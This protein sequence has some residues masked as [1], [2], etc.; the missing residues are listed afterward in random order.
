MSSTYSSSLRIELIGS[1]DQA[2]AWGATT[3]SNLA[4]IMDTAIAGYQA[5]TVTSAAQAL[6]YVNGPSA[7]ANLNQSVYAMLKFNSA[8][9]AS[10]I[11]AP[12]TSKQYI[13]WNN[14]SY[15]ITIY[16]STV[17]G[18]TTAAGTGVAIAA[19]NKV[20]VWSD[21]TSFYDVQA[22]STA[23]TVPI[24]NGGTGQTTANAAFNALAPAQTSTVTAGSF[25]VGAIY[26]ILTVGTTIW[27]SIGAASNTVGVTFTT[28]GIGSG[29]GT[30]TTKVPNRYLKSNGT[31]TAFDYLN[32]ADTT[33]VTAGSFTIGTAYTVKSLGTTN[34]V[35][36]GAASTAVVTGS[37]ATTVLTVTAV[38]SGALAVGTYI[39][40]TNI[41]TGTYITSFGTGTGGTG[42][43]NLNQSMTATSTTVTGQ[44]IPG[45]AFTATGV[46]SGT[47]TAVL[48]D[49]IGALPL[50]N[51]GTGVGSSAALTALIG[52]LIFP[53][54]AIYTATVSTNPGTLLGFGTW[55]AFGAGK[56]LIGNGVT[57]TVTVGSATNAVVTGSVSGTT[58]TVTARTSGTLAVGSYITGTNITVGTY[59]TAFTTAVSFTGATTGASTTLTASSVTGTIAVGQFV[60]G[61]NIASGTYISA[62]GT[63]TGGAG[64]YTLSTASSGTVD[65]IV[66]VIIGGRGAYTLNQSMT[67]SST[68]ITG[69]PVGNLAIGSKYTIVSAG[70]TSFTSIGAANNT[71]GTV[72]TATGYGT[73]TGTASKT[74]VGG[75]TGGSAD[76]IVPSHTHTGTT[77]NES[78]LGSLIFGGNC[79]PS[80]ATTGIFNESTESGTADQPSFGSGSENRQFDIDASHDHT[81]TTASTGSPE[82]NANLQPYIVA[83][84]WQRTV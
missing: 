43:Y 62:L 40:G 33:S 45:T 82:A 7:T 47:G 10:A 28:N 55:T 26:T 14:S 74:W 16:N 64:T 63:G 78:L 5:V 2:G 4:Y 52:N 83:Y 79:A 72:F 1:G 70:T 20:M 9:A 15:T 30:A 51:G 68:T 23:G 39:T 80:I 13:V 84:M 25:V 19:G 34:F 77:A 53:V 54:G 41:S 65:G 21:G 6:T 67:A 44:P 22:Q 59:I 27:T 76:A 56:V 58:L 32:L 11:Y 75:D 69:Q 12:P 36:I 71:V 29:T 3:D 35:T 18:N 73:G 57:D 66:N 49:Y 24:V 46:G 37:V 50:T 48:A 61:L 42:T 60:T 8:A 31:D 38:S 81:F 17:I